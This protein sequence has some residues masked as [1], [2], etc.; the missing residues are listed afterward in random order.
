MGPTA[1][2]IASVPQLS[3]LIGRLLAQSPHSTS[4]PGGPIPFI[5]TGRV[6]VMISRSLLVKKGSNNLILPGIKG[7]SRTW[8]TPGQTETTGHPTYASWSPHRKFI[9]SHTEC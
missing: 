1:D 3:I 7:F 9:K 6:A 2:E 5:D 4:S 8:E